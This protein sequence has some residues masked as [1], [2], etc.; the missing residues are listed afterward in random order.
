[1]SDE[2][3]DGAKGH[4]EKFSQGTSS[5]ELKMAGSQYEPTLLLHKLC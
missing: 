1:M 5:E 2:S 3:V 4:S